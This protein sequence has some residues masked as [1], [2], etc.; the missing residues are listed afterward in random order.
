MCGRRFSC[1]VHQ[2]HLYSMITF[3]PPHRLLSPPPPRLWLFAPRGFPRASRDICVKRAWFFGFKVWLYHIVLQ[4]IQNSN[5]NTELS[6]HVVCPFCPKK[7][8]EDQHQRVYQNRK[9]NKKIAY[10]K[11]RMR[12]VLHIAGLGRI[13]DAQH[14]I[15]RWTD[16]IYYV[17]CSGA[18]IG[19]SDPTREYTARKRYYLHFRVFF[20]FILFYFFFFFC[21]IYLH[22][23]GIF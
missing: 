10:Y 5:P 14:K 11:L 2:L 9:N 8:N 16:L 15:P 3:I 17:L 1:T 23:F 7:K 18:A 4:L 21:L 13:K 22:V 19:I 12:T 6:L 20:P